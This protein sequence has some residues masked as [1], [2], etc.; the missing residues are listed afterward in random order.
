MPIS[1]EP[2]S[3]L[4]TTTLPLTYHSILF[5]VHSSR[6]AF[7]RSSSLT[8]LRSI[9]DTMTSSLPQLSDM[10]SEES[11]P[12]LYHQPDASDNGLSENSVEDLSPKPNPAKRWRIWFFCF[13]AALVELG[14]LG[15]IFA[16]YTTKSDKHIQCQQLPRTYCTCQ[17]PREPHPP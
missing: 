12:F 16:H 3:R 1:A 5:A 15:I 6:C 14:Q 11:K 7:S 17:T 13:L 9:C 4:N 8:F 10:A 2:V